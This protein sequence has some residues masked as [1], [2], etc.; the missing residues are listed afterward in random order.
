M[1]PCSTK[2]QDHLIAARNILTGFDKFDSAE[3]LSKT[4]GRAAR[5]I[6]AAMRTMRKDDDRRRVKRIARLASG[7]PAARAKGL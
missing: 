3:F 7:V 5:R 6:D 2:A 1:L 4:M